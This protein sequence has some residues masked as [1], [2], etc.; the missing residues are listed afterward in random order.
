MAA[1]KAGV[2][3]DLD[4]LEVSL[5][6]IKIA[7]RGALNVAALPAAAAQ[8]K[9]PEFGLVLDLKQGKAKAQVTTC[10]LSFDYVK[11]NAEYTT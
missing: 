10:D 9:E 4:R 7:S 1:G 2:A 3:L 8:M 5:G 11:I 6:G